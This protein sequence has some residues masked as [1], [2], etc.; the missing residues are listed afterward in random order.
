MKT[1]RLQVQSDEA[2][3]EPS[4]P[5]PQDRRSLKDRRRF[6]RRERRGSRDLAVPVSNEPMAVASRKH[7][8]DT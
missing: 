3:R 7:D 1:A 8:E 5:P 4:Q 2:K 6:T